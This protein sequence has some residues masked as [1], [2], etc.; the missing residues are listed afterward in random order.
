MT[1]QDPSAPSTYLGPGDRPPVFGTEPEPEPEPETGPASRTARP[2]IAA[3]LC[4]L[5]FLVVYLT[6]VCTPFGQRAE[7]ALID[8]NGAGPAWIYD[9]SGAAYQSSALPPLEYTA[10]PTLLVGIAVIGSRSE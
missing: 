1:R 8:E 9:W 6:A 5:A 10:M 2:Y 3:L 4:L 7:N